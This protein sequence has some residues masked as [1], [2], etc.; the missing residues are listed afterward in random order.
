MTPFGEMIK[1]WR[2]ARRVSQLALAHQAEIS[3]RHISF[4]E[5]GRARPSREM[6]LVLASALDIPLR[7]RNQLLAAAGFAAVYAESEL[8]SPSWAPARR[9]IDAILRRQEPCPAVVMNRRW[10]VVRSNEGATWLFGWLLGEVDEPPN[11]LRL[12]FHPERLRPWVSNWDEVGPALIRRVHRE[13]LAGVLDAPTRALLSEILAW[14]P[15]RWRTVDTAAPLAPLVPVHFRK[16]GLTLR[17][18]STVTTLGTPQ[19]IALQELR[20]ECF[21]PEDEQTEAAMAKSRSAQ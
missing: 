16:D 2:A 6:V 10:D 11:V 3:A 21:F 8:A 5:T 4:L 18:F 17:F 12:M 14:V 19:D 1:E 15:P 9:A 20:I 13:A 7:E